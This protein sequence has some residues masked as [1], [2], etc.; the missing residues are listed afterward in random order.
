MSGVALG[1]GG[2]LVVP[3]H[4]VGGEFPSFKEFM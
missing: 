1:E 3:V 2:H 4:A